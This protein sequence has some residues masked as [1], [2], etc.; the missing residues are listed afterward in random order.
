MGID[1][2]VSTLAQRMDF[3]DR[4]AALDNKSWP[5]FLQNSDAQSWH[6]FYDQLSESVL[7][8]I[9]GERLIAA[10]FTV[11]I[12]WNG[13]EQ[14]LPVS[15]ESV[16]QRGL[17]LKAQQADGNT[18]VPIGA[19]VDSSVQGQGVSSLVLQEM[20]RF[21]RQQGLSHLVVPVRPTFKAK[22]PLQTI[23]SYTTW[24]RE[25]GFLFDPWLRVH[26]KLNAKVISI[27]DQTLSVVGTIEQWQQWT[28][29]HFAESGRYIVPGALSAVE[30]DISRNIGCYREPNVWMQHPM[31]A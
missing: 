8:L 16:L 29:M 26:E 7:L 3:I 4:L 15:I 14:D 11:V 19:L 1:Y 10:G 23:E 24:R 13:S 6:H 28:G 22:Y 9:S 17:T 27:S 20:K 5:V 30:V 12:D 2:Q 18:L 21:A 25:D 31:T